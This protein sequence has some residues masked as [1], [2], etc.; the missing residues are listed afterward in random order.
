MPEL[1]EVETVRRGLQPVLE[2]ARLVKVEARRP[3]LRFPFPER[4]SERL[5][6]KTVTALGRRAKYLTMHVEDGPVL[7]CHLGM[8]GSFRV[9]TAGS[10][11]V[12]G[13]FHHERSKI[14]A[15]D[16]VVFDVTSPMGV[17][18]SIIFN[19][20]RRFGFML[21]AE[22]SPDTHPML[23]G[24]GIEPTGNA[25][26]GPLLAS[27]LKDR[28]S[29]LKAALLDQRLIAGLGNIYVSEALWRAGLSPLREAGTITGSAKKAK[30][31]SE[32]LA[33]AIRSVIADAIA[34][35]GS[36]LRDYV[37]ADGSLGYFQHSFA[38]YDREGKPCQKPGCRGHVERIVQS[39]RS[40]FY[41]R[42]CQR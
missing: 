11:G 9:E 17:R 30:G 23:A 13:S 29:P 8:S 37:Q 36:S 21:F 22:G 42:T 18:S 33:E 32:R 41:C 24:L 3:D 25:L 27:L 6:G 19:D 10:S 2:G 26:D 28:R 4:F 40:T 5:T 39:G 31:Q 14:A 1:P 7:I 20:P 16:H 34:A 38:V 12:P 35:G 15:H